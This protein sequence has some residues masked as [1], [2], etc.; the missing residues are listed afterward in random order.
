M[1]SSSA[2]SEVAGYIG[3]LVAVDAHAVPGA[4]HEVL[5]IAAW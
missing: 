3:R 4:V 1:P 2:V 5:A